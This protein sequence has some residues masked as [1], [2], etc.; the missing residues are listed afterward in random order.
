FV[1]RRSA[2]RLPSNAVENVLVV[3]KHIDS[4]GPCGFAADVRLPRMTHLYCLPN[5]I[6]TN[7]RLFRTVIWAVIVTVAVM[8]SLLFVF[9]LALL[10]YAYEFP[11]TD[12]GKSLSFLYSRR[13]YI[14][15]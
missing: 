12:T 5:S 13:P 11:I 14:L 7:N 10:S 6:Q 4:E 1:C 15:V 2:C 8:R 3:A 9:L